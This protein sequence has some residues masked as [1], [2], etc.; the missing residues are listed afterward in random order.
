MT[1]EDL[2]ILFLDDL[3][4]KLTPALLALAHL[5]DAEDP[6]EERQSASIRKSSHADDKDEAM[7]SGPIRKSRR[8]KKADPYTNAKDDELVN[9]MK[10]LDFRTNAWKPFNKK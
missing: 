5:S 10:E 4:E 3:P 8:R 9:E 7:Q 6:V 1:D 2:S